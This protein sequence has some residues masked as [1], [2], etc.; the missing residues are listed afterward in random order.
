[1]A[2][3]VYTRTSAQSP[4][5]I[6]DQWAD[7]GAAARAAQSSPLP[8]GTAP[9]LMQLHADAHNALATALH[10]MRQPQANVR[11]ATRKAAQ[12]L[13]ALRCLNGGQ[14]GAA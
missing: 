13:A 2:D 6:F 4:Y 8:A 11:G 7:E 9:G 10:Y 14:G 1:M 3:S 5:T 12:A